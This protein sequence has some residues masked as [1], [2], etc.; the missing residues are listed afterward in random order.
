MNWEIRKHCR[1]IHKQELESITGNTN[2]RLNLKLYAC[3]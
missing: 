2:V 3:K 1:E